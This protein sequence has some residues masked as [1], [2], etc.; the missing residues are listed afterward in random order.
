[1]HVAGPVVFGDV[2]VGRRRAARMPAAVEVP[3]REE[4]TSEYS[5][6]FWYSGFV[7]GSNRESKL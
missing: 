7:D 3:F 6:Y 4:P 5:A 1:M 2:E